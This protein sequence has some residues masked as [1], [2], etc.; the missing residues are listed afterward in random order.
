MIGHDFDASPLHISNRRPCR[1]RT[2]EWSCVLL[3]PSSSPFTSLHSLSPDSA[4]LSPPEISRKKQ[5][6]SSVAQQP[7]STPPTHA[8]PDA[9]CAQAGQTHQKRPDQL[10]RGPVHHLESSCSAHTIETPAQKVLPPSSR[11]TTPRPLI[12][13]IHKHTLAHHG[14]AALG[15]TTT[16]GHA[17]QQQQHRR[18]QHAHNNRLLATSPK[19]Q[20][21]LRRPSPD[22]LLRHR[23][24]PRLLTVCR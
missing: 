10:A 23:F 12:V 1:A 15:A 17:G 8:L 6:T 18:S 7:V 16:S 21:H 19:Q 22:L 2:E 14:P 24:Q 11:T 20:P 4:S 9:H 5:K 13:H 3:I